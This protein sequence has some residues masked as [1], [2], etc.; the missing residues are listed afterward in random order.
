[1]NIEKKSSSGSDTETAELPSDI[2]LLYRHQLW[3]GSKEGTGFTQSLN[4]LGRSDKKMMIS[5]SCMR[6][7][8]PNLHKGLEL[9][10]L[11]VSTVFFELIQN[12]IT[13]T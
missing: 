7:F 5:Y 9:Y 10:L 11:R 4:N 6:G 3:T 2:F 8:I 12:F 13:S 1:M